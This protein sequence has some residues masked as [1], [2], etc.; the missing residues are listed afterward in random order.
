MYSFAQRPDT[1]VIDEPL[2]AHY[3][4]V[5]G[6]RHPGREQILAVM[7]QDGDAVM[8]RILDARY[9]DRVQLVFVKQM[10]HHLQ[11][12][13]RQLLRDT[14]HVLLIRDPREMLP[15][16]TVQLPEAT[17][18]DTGLPAQWELFREL[19]ARGEAPAVL[20]AR[21]LLLNPERVLTVLC[22]R[23]GVP[24]TAQM[25]SWPAGARPEDGVWAPIWYHAVHQSTGFARYLSKHHFPDA[26]RPLLDECVPYYDRLVTHAIRA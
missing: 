18:P 16:L 8:R 25:L 26:L 23:L 2:Y 15:S 9:D 1:A 13:D 5:S 21:E 14:E 3:L 22:E 20:D 10:A 7:D 19:E 12:L 11:E 6:A 24:F 17:L 4:R